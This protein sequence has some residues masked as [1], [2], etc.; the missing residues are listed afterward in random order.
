[1]AR[2]KRPGPPAPQKTTALPPVLHGDTFR[3]FL[4]EARSIG[5]ECDA[6]R[7]YDADVVEYLKEKGLF[8]EW[9]AWREAKHAPKQS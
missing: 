7:K 4:D 9:A 2:K 8:E 3:A 1:M 6:R 5:N